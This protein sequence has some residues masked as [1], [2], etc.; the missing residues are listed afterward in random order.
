MQ[1]AQNHVVQQTS[2][3]PPPHAHTHACTHTH[4][5]PHT[6]THTHIH[7]HSGHDW[8][9]AHDHNQL[10]PLTHTTLHRV[11]Y[12]HALLTEEEVL[13]LP[14]VGH[15]PPPL[16]APLNRYHVPKEKHVGYG[17]VRVLQVLQW[18]GMEVMKGI[19]RDMSVVKMMQFQ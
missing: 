13:V 8:P 14:I 15:F 3:V 1:L 10:L 2:P 4:T 6:R 19:I 5:H 7:T 12:V 16:L 9:L 17:D 18:V 11:Q